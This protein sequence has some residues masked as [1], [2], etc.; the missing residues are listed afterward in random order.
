M[1]FFVLVYFGILLLVIEEALRPMPPPYIVIISSCL[2]PHEKNFEYQCAPK[3]FLTI[4]SS[5]HVSS[6]YVVSNVE[7]I[8]VGLIITKNRRS[9][10][11][12]PNV[13]LV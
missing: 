4:C 7:L 13:G 8:L 11:N 10:Q 12:L 6:R 1:L 5:E 9:V 3:L 2:R